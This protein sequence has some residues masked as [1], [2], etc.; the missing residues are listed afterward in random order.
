[1]GQAG[2]ENTRHAVLALTL[3]RQRGVSTAVIQGPALANP[4]ISQLGSKPGQVTAPSHGPSPVLAGRL[5]VTLKQLRIALSHGLTSH[6]TRRLLLAGPCWEVA[7]TPCAAASRVH[8]DLF[9]DGS[10]P[11][12]RA[13]AECLLLSP[14]YKR[15]PGHAQGTSGGEAGWG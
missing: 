2:L 8:A 15:T 3:S 13:K 4:P 9:F 1:M 6:T 5:L 14:V 12:L 11:H 7:G 10:G